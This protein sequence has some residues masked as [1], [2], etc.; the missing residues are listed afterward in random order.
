[1]NLRRMFRGWVS[2]VSIIALL[3]AGC[4]KDL[5]HDD[6]KLAKTGTHCS[7]SEGMDDSSIAV[8]PVPVVAFFVPHFDLHEVKA[9]QYLQRCGDSTTLINRKVTINRTG[10]IPAGLTR[11]IT[12]GI[13]QWCPANISW[14][15]DV[16]TS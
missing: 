6:V 7:G 3:L 16:K 4:V 5:I 13:W 9:D 1:M 10:C 11:I 2:L 15:A 14:E 8:L 12:L